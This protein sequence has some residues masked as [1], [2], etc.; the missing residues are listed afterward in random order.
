ML[1][2]SD[3]Q[4]QQSFA[5]G[6]GAPLDDPD[7]DGQSNLAE[8]VSGSSPTAANP[9]HPG[10]VFQQN[11]QLFFSI[12]RRGDRSALITVEV[13]DD[14][15]TWHSGPAHLNIAQQTPVSLV[16]RDETFTPNSTRRFFRYHLSLE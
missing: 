5:P 10:L 6:E 9:A 8:F 15:I 12:P 14:L 16:V 7:Q 4:A 11:G 13:S 3:W 1:T 2:Y